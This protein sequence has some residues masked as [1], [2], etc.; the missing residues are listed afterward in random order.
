MNLDTDI[1]IT[2]AINAGLLILLLWF[3]ILWL[4]LR[5]FRR[6]GV[7]VSGNKAIDPATYA[8]CQQSVES[9]LNYSA[10]NSNTLNDLVDIQQALEDQVA[11]IRAENDRML[12]EQDNGT[13]DS[14]NTKL[15]KSH[16]LINTLRINLDKSVRGLR[17][18]KSKLAQQNTTV[19]GLR[20]E[21]LQ[22]EKEFAQLENEYIQ[23]SGAGNVTDVLKE[24]QQEK[25][26]LLNTIENYKKKL[27]SIADIEQLKSEL[28]SANQQLQHMS[29]EKEFI[30]KKYLE[31]VKG[32]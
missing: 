32:S 26:R 4:I 14:L 17:K 22:L 20:M 7:E 31:L 10:D 25:E 15:S 16:Q 18:A 24:H 1:L 19:E 2:L 12:S 9:A 13:I 11:Q 23:I 21:K 30:E 6:F 3:I 28:L 8:L 27:S 5:E 29:K